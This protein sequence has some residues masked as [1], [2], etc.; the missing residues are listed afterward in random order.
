M[1]K[2]NSSPN[3]RKIQTELWI[4]NFQAGKTSSAVRK[5]YETN[6][7]NKK[8]IPVF[9]AYGTN[10]T[11]EN[12][13]KHIRRIYGSGCDLINTAEA[14]KAFKVRAQK[15]ALDYY[16]TPIVISVLGHWAGLESLQS[17]LTTKSDFEFH[18]WLDESDT[19]SLAFDKQDVTARKDNLID[20]IKK[21][22]YHKVVKIHCITAT[23]LTEL[24]NTTDFSVDPIYIEPGEGY[25]GIATIFDRAEKVRQEAIRD[26]KKGLISPELQDYF[27]EDAR[28]VNT[29]TIIST[30]NIMSD[31]KVQAQSIAKLVNS[32]KVLVVEFN[33]NRGVKYFSKDAIR[34][35][36]K[37][38]RKDQLQEMF[39]IAQNYDKLFIVGS[40]MIDRS[41]TLK[42][43]K[44]QTY[45]S[46][47]FSAGRD[48][49][50]APL[51]Q[52]VARICGYQTDVPILHT[53]LSDK[54]FLAGEAFEMYIE[55]VR[56]KPKYADRRA[57]LLSLGE[58]FH[59][60]PGAFGRYRNNGV[61]PQAT[62]RT[63]AYR[64]ENRGEAEAYGFQ[65]INDVSHVKEEDLKAEIVQQLNEGKKCSSGSPLHKFISNLYF[66]VDKIL[67]VRD[68]DGKTAHQY[69][70]LPNNEDVNNFRNTLYFWE[71]NTLSVSNQ[72]YPRVNRSYAIQD[73]TTRD[74]PQFDCYNLER[75]GKFT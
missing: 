31:H 14:F 50:L 71:D 16:N 27:I 68:A 12:Q 21:L 10:S 11:K 3:G 52:R 43:G 59:I 9:I 72:P 1:D 5:A 44:F 19:Y 38:N 49:A 57:A 13:E 48:P 69:Y 51:L 36:E 26:F 29:V 67:N 2:H 39:D 15:G 65:I 45:S 62:A 33:S 28:K 63:V 47:L 23:P 54:L 74:E 18:L 4:G 8:I 7:T 58:K 40:S 66:T 56:D 6:K 37:R 32:N 25:I 42:G 41:V 70:Q 60:F 46:M 61:V 30:S 55:M 20:S 73:L 64:A 34:V 22:E 24:L 53:D 35:T 75:G 17:I